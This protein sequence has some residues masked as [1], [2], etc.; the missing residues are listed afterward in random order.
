[1]Q[2]RQMKFLAIGGGS[3]LLAC[4]SLF[5]HHGTNASYQ[6]DKMITLN[7]VVTDFSFAYPHVQLYFDVKDEAGKLDHWASELPGTPIML[8]SYGVGWSK[9][10]VKPGDEIILNCHPAKAVGARVCLGAKLLVNGKE[11][12]FRGPSSR[13]NR[14]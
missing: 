7:G 6:L 4:A 14:Q 5:A 11:L 2:F 9:T 13:E 1:M 12:P 10:A 8:R 3:L